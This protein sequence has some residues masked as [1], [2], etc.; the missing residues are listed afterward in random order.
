MMLDGHSFLRTATTFLIPENDS[1]AVDDIIDAI[2]LAVPSSEGV[3]DEIYQDLG[4]IVSRL[5][6]AGYGREAMR[7]GRVWI[8]SRPADSQTNI[9]HFQALAPYAS[10]LVEKKLVTTASPNTEETFQ[11]VTHHYSQP[12]SPTLL[13]TVA[14]TQ[15]DLGGEWEVL[16]NGVRHYDTA[17]HFVTDYLNA[18][19]NEWRINLWDFGYDGSLRHN[20]MA[21]AVDDF[22]R[23]MTNVDMAERGEPTVS[24]FLTVDYLVINVP[25][26][27]NE[28]E[29]ALLARLREEQEQL[30]LSYMFNSLLA[31]HP[32]LTLDVVKNGSDTDVR[33]STNYYRY[34]ASGLYHSLSFQFIFQNGKANLSLGS[35]PANDRHWGLSPHL[36]EVDYTPKAGGVITD[37]EFI[38]LFT[39]MIAKVP[40]TPNRRG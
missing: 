25:G 21:P 16:P 6:K 18:E 5:A 27:P 3:T 30:Q 7:L 10:K 34:F 24:T 35:R 28:P 14:S 8:M 39:Q 4:E 1:A 26:E 32:H 22:T 36:E 37:E 17:R 20:S 33:S 11:Q 23:L 15:V 19:G 2:A 12:V 29:L 40:V 31:A 9:R 38:M 13:H